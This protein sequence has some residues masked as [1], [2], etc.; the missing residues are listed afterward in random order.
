[1]GGAYRLCIEVKNLQKVKQQRA[2]YNSSP[3]GKDADV[4]KVWR[5]RH[6]L[7]FNGNTFY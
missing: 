7:L 3:T 6:N 5:T 2:D 4:M 1:M